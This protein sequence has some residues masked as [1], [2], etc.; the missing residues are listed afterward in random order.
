MILRAIK[1]H[2]TLFKAANTCL[3]TSRPT[4]IVREG[5]VNF[6]GASIKLIAAR[7]PTQTKVMIHARDKSVDRFI[8][9]FVDYVCIL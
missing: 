8:S 2:S 5:A 7:N 1:T 9:W 4:A 6:T 3:P